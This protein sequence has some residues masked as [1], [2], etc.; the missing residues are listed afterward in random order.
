MVAMDRSSIK[1][2]NNRNDSASL[3]RS[4]LEVPMAGEEHRD[5]MAIAGS[6]D[7]LILP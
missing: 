2:R 1:K 5:T 7:F 4:V 6:D 3:R